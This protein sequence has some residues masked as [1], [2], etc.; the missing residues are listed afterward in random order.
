MKY[1][2]QAIKQLPELPDWQRRVRIDHIYTRDMLD[3]CRVSEVKTLG[4]VIA[5]GEG[6]IFCSTERLGPCPDFYELERATNAWMPEGDYGVRVE[7]E[8]STKFVASDTLKGYLRRG[9]T[10][11]IIA[12]HVRTRGDIVVFAPLVMGSPWLASDGRKLDF[13]P[14]WL[15]KD[16][17]ENYIEDVDEFARVVVTPEPDSPAPMEHISEQAFKYCLAMILGD[18][19]RGDWGG[20]NSDFYSA[21]VRI[22]GN[23]TNG[24]FLLKGPARFAPMDLNHLGKN[25]DQI[26]RLSQ[27]PAGLLVVQHCHDILPPVRGTLRAFAVQP[28][29]PRRY[30]L[31]D[32]RDSLRLLRAY[33]LYDLALEMSR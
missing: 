18:A 16:F 1:V 30:C 6:R 26:Y 28:S 19:V 3:W 12:E 22:K 11:S 23:R 7:F 29:N 4:A 2:D 9:E 15:A 10:V 8:Y 32:G 14:E 33:G 5:S 20:E 17:Y 27:E 25:N 31:I 13:A 24:A 21:H